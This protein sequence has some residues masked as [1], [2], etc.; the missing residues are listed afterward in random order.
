MGGPDDAVRDGGGLAAGF[1][2]VEAVVADGL[3]AFRWKVK[4]SGSDEIRRFEDLEVALGGVVAF[5]AVNDGLGGGVPGDFLERE[6]MAQQIL[7]EALATR[8]VVGGDGLFAAVVDAE[9]GVFPGKEIGQFGG[10]DEFGVAEGVE[11]VVAEEF[12]GGSEI[13]GG[14]AVEAAIRGEESICGKNVEVGVENEVVSEGVDGGDG[15]DSTL[16]EAEA[17]PKGVLEGGGG[18]VEE[19]GE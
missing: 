2:G 11:E 3:L 4:E 13:F 15:P 1:V 14:H 10:T 5:G 19:E 6:R 18:R 16:E 9:T 7:G 17:D 12:D 8:G